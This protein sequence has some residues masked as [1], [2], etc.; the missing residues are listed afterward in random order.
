MADARLLSAAIRFYH[1]FL[2]PALWFRQPPADAADK[3]AAVSDYR[4]RADRSDEVHNGG[5][6]PATSDAESG[7]SSDEKIYEEGAPAGQPLHHD[8]ALNQEVE[9]VDPHPIE[10]A[11]AEPK[12]LWII[13]RYKSIPWI[14]NTLTHGMRY[15]IHKVCP[16]FPS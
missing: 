5:I 3:L 4:I 9:K 1:F 7:P 10:G 14:W 8:S 16:P 15:D 11:W 6:K 13:L 12:N 2:G